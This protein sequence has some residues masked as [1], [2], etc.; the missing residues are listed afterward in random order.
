MKL[1]DNGTIFKEAY[2]ARG[3]ADGEGEAFGGG[4]DAGGGGMASA[5]SQ[6]DLHIVIN[7]RKVASCGEDDTIFSDDEGAI[8][9]GEVFNGFS[10]FGV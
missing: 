6:G 5:H 9:H 4:G 3:L 8:Q 10:D 2:S 7:G 1:E